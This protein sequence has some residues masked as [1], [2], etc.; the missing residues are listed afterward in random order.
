MFQN[1]AEFRD[2]LAK[3]PDVDWDNLPSMEET[4]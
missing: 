4:K 2:K 1:E 3:Y